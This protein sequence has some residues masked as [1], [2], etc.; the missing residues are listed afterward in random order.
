M[1]LQSPFRFIEKPISNN[2]KFFFVATDFT[3][4]VWRYI[5]SLKNVSRMPASS[6]STVITILLNFSF[7]FFV[8]AKEYESPWQIPDTFLKRV[9]WVAMI[10]MHALFFVTIPDCRRPG[11]W[12]R[13]YPVTF[14]MSIAWI[15]GLSYIMVWMVT[16]AGKCS[17]QSDP[18]WPFRKSS[19]FKQ[20]LVQLQFLGSFRQSS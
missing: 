5:F 1:L 17:Q 12:H 2:N 16:V 18:F 14:V 11:R 7:N 9:F 3:Y 8:P 19:E 10:P 6:L 13:T 4:L 15:A 20:I